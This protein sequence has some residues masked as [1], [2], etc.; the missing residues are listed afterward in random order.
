M[1]GGRLLGSRLRNYGVILVFSIIIILSFLSIFTNVLLSLI[2]TAGSITQGS[3]FSR[4]IGEGTELFVMRRFITD[5]ELNLDLS[6]TA[7][8]GIQGILP[9]YKIH[10]IPDTISNQSAVA[11]NRSVALANGSDE[12]TAVLP[13]GIDTTGVHVTNV[14]VNGGHP[15]WWVDFRV[16]NET[17]LQEVDDFLKEN[18]QFYDFSL[19]VSLN[20]IDSLNVVSCN[21]RNTQMRASTHTHSY[22][23]TH[24]HIATHTHT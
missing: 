2:L 10:T 22:T 6:D 18:A 9:G 15:W 7:I 19:T 11:L 16:Q 8:G 14:S 23:H 3:L 1:F 4:L 21:H 20:D 17:F 24:T 13:P 5:A 12:T